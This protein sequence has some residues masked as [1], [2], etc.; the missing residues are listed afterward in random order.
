MVRNTIISIFRYEYRVHCKDI[1]GDSPQSQRGAAT[2]MALF[3]TKAMLGSQRRTTATACAATAFSILI[4]IAIVLG[5]AAAAVVVEE[6][7]P[8]RANHKKKPTKQ[9]CITTLLLKATSTRSGKQD[10]VC[11]YST[12]AHGFFFRSFV[13]DFLCMHILTGTAA[14]CCY[15]R[16]QPC[17][18]F[19][20]N[21]VL[22]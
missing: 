11:V 9:P 6:E 19:R 1:R 4:L 12:Q 8:V 2:T 22:R 17:G 10:Y 5:T 14:R 18:A 3:C 13:V 20:Q 16:K 21:P 7:E 15:R